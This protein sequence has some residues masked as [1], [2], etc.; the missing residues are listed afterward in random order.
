MQLN[1]VIVVRHA[2]DSNNQLTLEGV[3]QAKLAA[4]QIKT[5]LG[6]KKAIVL[7]TRAKRARTTAAII[8]R[9]LGSGP[10]LRYT[11]GDLGRLATELDPQ[12][13]A[14]ILVGHGPDLERHVLRYAAQGFRKLAEPRLAYSNAA[15]WCADLEKR[16]LYCGTRLL[17]KVA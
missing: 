12:A 10:T 1:K 13:Y 16:T 9:E 4:K 17:K 3:A 7:A 2:K 14:I 11:D 8:S 6:G 15:F 5:L